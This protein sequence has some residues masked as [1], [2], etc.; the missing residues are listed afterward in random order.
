[1][2]RLHT[3]AV[4]GCIAILIASSPALAAPTEMQATAANVEDRG[5]AGQLQEAG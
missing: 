2:N 5:A 4:L 3:L 1:M